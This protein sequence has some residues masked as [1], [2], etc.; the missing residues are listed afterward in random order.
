LTIPALQ[1]TIEATFEGW[2]AQEVPLERFQLKAP[3]GVEA[4]RFQLPQ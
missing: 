4:Q 3:S 2:K 1:S